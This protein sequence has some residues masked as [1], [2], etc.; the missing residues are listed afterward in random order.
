MKKILLAIWQFPQFLLGRLLLKLTEKN[1]SGKTR[2]EIATIRLWKRRGF[3][4]GISLGDNVFLYEDDCGL[5][6]IGHELGH[7]RQSQ[8]LGPLYLLVVGVPSAVFN[9]LWDRTFHKK[10]T[11]RERYLWYYSRFPE[12]WADELGGVRRK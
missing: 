8:I 12:K 5:D 6:A 7:S 10:W 11:P 2:V 9:N 3:L 4:S 1:I